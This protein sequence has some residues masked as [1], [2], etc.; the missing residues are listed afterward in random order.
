[1]SDAAWAVIGV[2]IG[3]AALLCYLEDGLE[4]RLKEIIAELRKRP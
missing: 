4:K 3:L 2:G 1:M